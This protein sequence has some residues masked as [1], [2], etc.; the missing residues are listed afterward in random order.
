[1]EMLKHNAGFLA[2][3]FLGVFSGF[4]LGD[5]SVDGNGAFP[6]PLAEV[7][8]DMPPAPLVVEQGLSAEAQAIFDNLAAEEKGRAPVRRSTMGTM[9][10]S[11]KPVIDYP[12]GR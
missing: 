1:M 6:R 10:Y 11:S 12:E 2:G 5:P 3:A 7:A 4:A 8:Q 9:I